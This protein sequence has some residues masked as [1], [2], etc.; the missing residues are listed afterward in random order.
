MASPA[1]F[2]LQ[3]IAKMFYA[4]LSL[5]LVGGALAQVPSFGNCPTVDT[6]PDFKLE[7]VIEIIYLDF[8]CK[9]SQSLKF[10]FWVITIF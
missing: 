6:V 4:I 3:L 10:Y 2:R 9:K 5:C 7:K 8:L 1:E